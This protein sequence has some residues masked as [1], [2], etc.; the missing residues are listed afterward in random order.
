MQTKTKLIYTLAILF[1]GSLIASCSAEDG[2]TGPAGP[3]GPQGEQGPAGAN[4][5]DGAQGEQGEQGDPGTANVMY[6]D[7]ID[8]ELGNNIV[9]ASASFVIDAPDIDEDMLDFGTILVYARRTDVSLG[10]LVYP[11]PVVFGAARQQ[12]YYFR[13]QDG[14]IRISVATN[15]EGESAG[16]GSFLEQYRYVLI[17]GGT[18]VTSG[19]PGGLGSKAVDYSKMTYEQVAKHFNFEE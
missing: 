6:S 10:S 5:A 19:P 16:D 4:G 15:E 1:I 12:S 17:P 8:T 11:L 2:E 7:W 14:E 9:G 13:A 3:Q 18:P